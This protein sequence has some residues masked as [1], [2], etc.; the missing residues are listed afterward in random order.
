[1][2]RHGDGFEHGGFSEGKI[3]GESMNDASGHHDKLGKCS[4]ATVISAGNAQHLAAIAKI[5]VS[6]QS[7]W[8]T[9]RNRSSNRK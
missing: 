1:M 3:V 9:R 8:R 5:D 4:R 7:N 6:A 2:K